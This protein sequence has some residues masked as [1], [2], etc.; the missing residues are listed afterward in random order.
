MGLLHLMLAFVLQACAAGPPP[1]PSPLQI[2]GMEA[3][4][5][6]VSPFNIVS[7]LPPELA[8]SIGIVSTA[9]IEHLEAHDKEVH[10]IGFQAGRD[11]WRMSMKE[12]RESGLPRN[13]KNAA[14]VYAQKI[15]EQIE[16]DAIIVPS[17]F[18]QNANKKRSRIVRWDGAEQKLE[19]RGDSRGVVVASIYVKAASLFV[20]IL[21]REGNAIHTKRMGLELIQHLRFGGERIRGYSR[22]EDSDAQLINNWKVVDDAPPIQDEE[23]VRA[24][25]A[26]V[27][28][29]YLSE[30]VPHPISEMPE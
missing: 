18:V 15:G 22:R 9:L 4:T 16:F 24:G 13:F 20:H 25:V 21:D 8:G 12:V 17:I 5:I 3:R 19:Y 6:I 27:L 7:S 30:E 14:R 28:S 26:A 1:A 29:P 2:A 23:R 11:L 10:V